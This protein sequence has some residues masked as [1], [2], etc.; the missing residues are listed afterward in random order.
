ML[1][2]SE[3]YKNASGAWTLRHISV[4]TGNITTVRE[5]TVVANLI[6]EGQSELPSGANRFCTI[7]IQAGGTVSEV[8]VV[9]GLTEVE[10]L[11]KGASKRRGVLLG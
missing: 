4:N 6:S 7:V 3:V 5:N 9:G 2:F 1:K 11:V 8:V 10:M